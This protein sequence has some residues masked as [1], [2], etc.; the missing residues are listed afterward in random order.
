M[1]ENEIRLLLVPLEDLVVFPNMNV[2]LTVEVGD[3]ERVLLVPK[4]DDGYTKVGTVAEVTDRIRLR[5]GVALS[6]STAST[7]ALP[8]LP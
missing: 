3:E 7:A 6:R 1:S 2:T 8:A 4:H 5:A